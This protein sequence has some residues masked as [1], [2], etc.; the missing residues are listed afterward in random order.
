MAALGYNL[1]LLQ[2]LQH[3]P[4]WLLLKLCGIVTFNVCCRFLA[5]RRSHQRQASS[6]VSSVRR[7]IPLSTP[8]NIQRSM[9]RLSVQSMASVQQHSVFSPRYSTVSPQSVSMSVVVDTQ[10]YLEEQHIFFSFLTGFVAPVPVSSFASAIT[11]L[12][13]SPVFMHWQL[14]QIMLHDLTGT[15]V[16]AHILASAGIFPCKTSAFLLTSTDVTSTFYLFALAMI[17]LST[18]HKQLTSMLFTCLLVPLVAYCYLYVTDRPV[19][20]LL[21]ICY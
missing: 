12:Q 14:H 6:L 16:L 17:S 4:W 13:S 18:A 5:Q 8:S 19:G 15:S 9:V 2:L 21:S 11:Q 20:L 3:E 7:S 1:T 10:T